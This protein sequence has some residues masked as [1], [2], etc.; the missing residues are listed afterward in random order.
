M[1]PHYVAG[2]TSSV[3]SVNC[4]LEIE[5]TCYCIAFILH[6]LDTVASDAI[7]KSPYVFHRFSYL[8]ALCV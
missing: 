6:E 7:I 5:T 1:C 3:K 8:L 2:L 4:C